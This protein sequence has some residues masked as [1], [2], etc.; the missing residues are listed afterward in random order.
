MNFTPALLFLSHLR[1]EPRRSGLTAAAASINSRPNDPAAPTRV[2][3]A[4]TRTSFEP[5]KRSFSS[6]GFDACRCVVAPAGSASA[7][8]RAAAGA[9]AEGPTV[10]R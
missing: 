9:A 5:A 3:L 2:R 4:S 8:G 6:G 1:G 10:S 7:T